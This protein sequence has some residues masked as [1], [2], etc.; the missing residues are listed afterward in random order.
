MYSYSR[1]AAAAKIKPTVV[2]KW[3]PRSITWTLRFVVKVPGDANDLKELARLEPQMGKLADDFISDMGEGIFKLDKSLYEDATS[4]TRWLE[5]SLKVES[6]AL[7]VVLTAQQTFDT[8]ITREHLNKAA[9]E[10]GSYY[11]TGI[12]IL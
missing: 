8:D 4:N 9:R 10:M 5:D 3:S 12:R 2:G 6:G 7:V 11:T 1:T